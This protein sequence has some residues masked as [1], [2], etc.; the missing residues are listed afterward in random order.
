MLFDAATTGSKFL[1]ETH[2]DFI[3]DR[4]R[5][6]VSLKKLD[7]SSQVLFFERKKDKNVVRMIP[8]L[9]NGQYSEKQPKS[10]R[11]FFYNEALKN[12]GI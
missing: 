7:K 5:Q 2:S 12:L 9:E 11:D 4:F 3:V 1:V 8:I 10:F 6:Q